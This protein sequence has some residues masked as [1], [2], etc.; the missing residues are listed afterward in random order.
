[1]IIKG[2]T[3]K[4]K[5]LF[6]PPFIKR[7]FQYLLAIPQHTN[8]SIKTPSFKLNQSNCEELIDVTMNMKDMILLCLHYKYKAPFIKGIIKETTIGYKKHVDHALLWA[9]FGE[10]EIFDM[11]NYPSTINPMEFKEEEM[12]VEELESKYTFT[13]LATIKPPRDVHN[14]EMLICESM[15]VCRVEK[16]VTCSITL[17]FGEVWLLYIQEITLRRVMTYI[18]EQILYSFSPYDW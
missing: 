10:I 14:F 4:V 16:D 15:C 1:M 5:V 3:N 8:E 7:L 6:H 2:Q 18:L 12:S 13:K 17:K 9:V 11:T